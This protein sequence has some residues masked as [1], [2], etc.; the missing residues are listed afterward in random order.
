[1]SAYNRTMGAN[2]V[3]Q[4][5]P[6]QILANTGQ[7]TTEDKAKAKATPADAGNANE[8]S[9]NLSPGK[10]SMTSVIV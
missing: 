5:K 8:G 9:V 2:K 4:P 10:C 6:D 3:N 1:M 7:E